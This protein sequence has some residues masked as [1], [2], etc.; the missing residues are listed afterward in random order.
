MNMTKARIG[1]L[2]A[3]V[4]ATAMLVLVLHLQ[5]AT[6]LDLIPEGVETLLRLTVVITWI[7]Y[8]AATYTDRL[9]DHVDARTAALHAAI[10]A[11]PDD[12]E[13]DTDATTAAHLSALRALGERTDGRIHPPRGR[14]GPVTPLLPLR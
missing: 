3:A 4:G 12:A 7:G 9:S 8:L 10:T 13:D 2:I 1:H 6:H 14:G 5:G 11:R